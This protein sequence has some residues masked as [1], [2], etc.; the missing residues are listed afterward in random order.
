[1]KTVAYCSPFIPPEWIAAHGLQPEWTWLPAAGNRPGAG[2]GRAVCPFAA[3]LIDRAQSGIQAL[4]IVLT[5][6]CDQM[7]Y[8]AAVLEHRGDLPV[9]LLNVPSTWQT[10]AARNLY[11]DEL[12]RLG[13]FLVRLGGE[14][15]SEEHLAMVMLD[16][17]SGRDKVHR[18]QN[19]GIPLALVGGPLFEKD[20]V[21]LEL[22]EQAG[23]R[24]VLDAT[25]GGERTQPA[26]LDR[27]QLHENPFAE[28][29]QAYFG[30]IPDAF[31]RPNNRLY[32]WLGQ[33]VARRNVRGILFRRYVWCDIWHAELPRMKE[34]S[35][36]PVLDIDVCGDDESRS[37]TSGR[38]EAF[39]EMLKSVVP[40]SV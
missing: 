17:E 34:W 3:A 29:A 12:K 8:A 6:T 18:N 40:N 22:I 27:R 14:P 21:I 32:K 19:N 11:D 10:A 30:A 5:T 28:L 31:R 4:A 2:T 9:F 33:E 26:K 16:Y 39:L 38:I 1:M 35:P 25:E 23:G 7:R 36:V 20:D 13:R 15:P 24:L 37:R